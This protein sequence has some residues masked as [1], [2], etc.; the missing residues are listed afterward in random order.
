MSESVNGP[1]T[2]PEEEL[3][4]GLS[5]EL[6][7]NDKLLLLNFK[8]RMSRHVVDAFYK[9]Y[10]A[11]GHSQAPSPYRWVVYHFHKSH[12]AVTPYLGQRVNQIN[13]EHPG[14]KGRI[15]FAIENPAIRHIMQFFVKRR[16]AAQPELAFEFFDSRQ[17]AMAWVKAGLTDHRANTEI[18]EEDETI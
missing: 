8:E 3:A 12:I 10:V 18:I 14:E 7:E 4:T 16:Q 11:Y 17:Q 13:A 2:V 5:R 15:A 1:P 6:L 9:A